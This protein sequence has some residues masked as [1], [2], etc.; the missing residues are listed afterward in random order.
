MNFLYLFVSRYTVTEFINSYYLSDC[1]TT[2]N[3][4]L[5][6]YHPDN[7]LFIQLLFKFMNYWHYNSLYERSSSF[8]WL[9]LNI[10][11]RLFNFSCMICLGFV[12]IFGGGAAWSMAI[13]VVLSSFPCNNIT[14][15]AVLLGSVPPGL[16][17]A[18]PHHWL[19]LGKLDWKGE[20]HP[21]LVH[22]T[23]CGRGI[24]NHGATTFPT[25]A[26]QLQSA[27][28]VFVTVEFL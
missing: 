25:Q 20:E 10:F 11:E 4:N 3:Y 28:G 14:Q 26:A 5:H 16:P 18:S 21:L 23:G 27:V 15:P 19:F 7:S 12:S 2:A 6:F 17:T 8:L 9:I 22:S 24:Q 13:F 1:F